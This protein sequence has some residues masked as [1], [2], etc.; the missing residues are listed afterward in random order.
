MINLETYFIIIHIPTGYSMP[1]SSRK[2][3]GYTSDEPCSPDQIP[4][5]LFKREQDAKCAL[6][7]WLKGETSVS[8]Y[9]DYTGEWDEDW[10]TSMPEIKSDIGMV[11]RRAEDMR[12]APVA[13]FLR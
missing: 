2:R 10:N 13:L 12:I 11:E 7:W 5:R 8:W 9:K 6:A 3:H 1:Q 4:P